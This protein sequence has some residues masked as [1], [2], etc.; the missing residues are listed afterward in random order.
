MKNLFLLFVCII[1]VI[2]AFLMVAVPVLLTLYLYLHGEYIACS[3][4]MAT[5]ILEILLIISEFNKK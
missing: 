5:F 2:V 3:I 4:T 1:S